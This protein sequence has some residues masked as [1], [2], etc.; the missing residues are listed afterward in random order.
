MGTVPER[1]TSALGLES[2]MVLS[3]CVDAGDQPWSSGRAP[4]LKP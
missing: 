2:Q 1:E 4:V 3:S